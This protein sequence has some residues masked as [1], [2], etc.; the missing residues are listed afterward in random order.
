MIS[1]TDGAQPYKM[2]KNGIWRF[3]ATINEA[4]YKLRRAYVILLALWFG[5]KKP[6]LHA[7]L[8]WIVKKWARL[9]KR[10]DKCKRNQLQGPCF[11][12]YY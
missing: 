12:Y 6:P 11:G 2:R 3:M 1:N 10:R 7:F 4:P 9:K 8:D 5:N